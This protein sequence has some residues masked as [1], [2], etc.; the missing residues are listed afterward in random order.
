MTE[1]NSKKIRDYF[2]GHLSEEAAA[3]FLEEVKQDA[4]LR[5]QFEIEKQLFN[6]FSDQYHATAIPKNDQTAALKDFLASDEA[7]EIKETL[8]K[9]HKTYSQAPKKS[10]RRIWYL[11]ASIV[12]LLGLTATQF[13]N[14]NIS[15]VALYEEYYTAKD[16]PNLTTR[17]DE[18][19]L[20]KGIMAFSNANYQE[21]ISHFETYLLETSKV[22]PEL[23]LYLG[24]AYQAIDQ[25]DKA[26]T[27]YDRLITADAL[28]SDKGYWFKAM[29]LL[30]FGNNEAAKESLKKLLASTQTTFKHQE[31]E[32]ILNALD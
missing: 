11:A 8:R 4:A 12:L 1:A 19:L 20:S 3:S 23:Y 18:S 2:L 17:G 27:A 32:A 31:A 29:A 28:S 24:A 9:A 26:I 22:N 21:A 7:Q 6:Q 14:N 25:K 15:G 10:N 13:F 16:L 5:E 30:K